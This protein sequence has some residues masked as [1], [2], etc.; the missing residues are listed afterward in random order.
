[1]SPPDPQPNPH[2]DALRPDAEREPGDPPFKDLR[3]CA[4]C[5]MPETNEGMAFDEMGICKACRSSEEKMRID[6]ARRQESLRHILDEAKQNSGNNYDCVV[7]ISGGKDSAFQLHLLVKVFGMTPLAVTF[8]HNWFTETGKQNL[9]N[10]LDKLEV[11]HMMYTPNRGLVNKLARR[12]LPMIG[13]S[14]WHCHAGVWSYPF[15]V[16]VKFGIPLIIYGESPAEFSGRTTYWEQEMKSDKDFVKVGLLN[17]IKVSPDRMIGDGISRKDLN[18]FFPPSA[19]EL[20]AAGIYGLFLGDFV[21][22]DHERQTE[23]LVQEYG[24]KEDKVEGSY[25]WYKSVEC[26]MAGV[27]D[28]AKYIKRGFGRGTDF[29]S[30]DVRAGLMNRDEAFELAGKIDAERP[31]ELDYYLGITGYTEEQFYEILRAKREGRA[32]ELP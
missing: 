23:F 17:S 4:R 16:A 7:P 20:E 24:W 30:Q 26:R 1:M 6:W 2:P 32:V 27:H 31:G 19:A 3:Y 15:H 8:S 22:W 28:Y 14:C 18:L 11:D 21:F 5:C 29:A 25:K 13:D 12:L 9:W 10:I